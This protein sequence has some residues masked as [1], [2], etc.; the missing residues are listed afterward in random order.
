MSFNLGNILRMYKKQLYD[1]KSFR[2]I[3]HAYVEPNDE[4]KIVLPG[5]LGFALEWNSSQKDGSGL[6]GYSFI[7]A[8][9]HAECRTFGIVYSMSDPSA[10]IDRYLADPKNF[11]LTIQDF[12]FAHN[13]Y[14]IGSLTFEQ[15]GNNSLTYVYIYYYG[16]GQQIAYFRYDCE[17]GIIVVNDFTFTDNTASYNQYISELGVCKQ[18]CC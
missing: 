7:V 15:V 9:Y 6:S 11:V 13:T 1:L 18:K 5:A 17:A 2:F 4:V 3:N 14:Q 12:A 8:L 16:D 10:L